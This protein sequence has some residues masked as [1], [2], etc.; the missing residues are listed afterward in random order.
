MS[1]ELVSPRYFQLPPLDAPGTVA[2]ATST[3]AS[4]PKAAPPAV[5]KAL[6]K[7]VSTL[8]EMKE[9]LAGEPIAMPDVSRAADL[10]LD[11]SWGGLS[12]R[13]SSYTFLPEDRYPK[14][15][16]ANEL[17][18]TLFPDGLSFLKLPYRQEWAES[19]RRLERIEMMGL[20]AKIHEVAGRDHLE[21][22]RRAHL[23]YGEVLGITRPNPLAQAPERAEKLRALRKA[24]NHYVLNLLA[25]LDEEDPETE[26][27]VRR[28]LQPIDEFRAAAPG[29]RSASDDDGP[30]TE[31]PPVA[32][33]VVASPPPVAVGGGAAPIAPSPAP[34][35][36]RSTPT[37]APS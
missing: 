2:M 8:A 25:C 28:A 30:E 13:I 34:I 14:V 37:D 27:M 1:N 10:S 33:P 32:S 35:P 17:M 5:K 24:L 6:K 7:V 26:E 4:A 22:V 12:G 9:V 3:L 29:R 18:R 31:V 20:E 11:R 21:E 23:V 36:V 15:S 19:E 16:T